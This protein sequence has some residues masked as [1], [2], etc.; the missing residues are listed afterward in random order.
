MFCLKTDCVYKNVCNLILVFFLFKYK[1][2]RNQKHNHHHLGIYLFY[3]Y[4]MFRRKY[5][6]KGLFKN[7]FKMTSFYITLYYKLALYVAADYR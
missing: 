1:F 4:N 3:M 2:P 5:Y 7:S 6:V